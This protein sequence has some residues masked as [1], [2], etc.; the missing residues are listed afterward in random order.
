MK[1]AERFRLEADAAL[2]KFRIGRE[3]LAEISL[4]FPIYTFIN[5]FYSLTHLQFC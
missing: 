3:E 4:T 1:I 5:K 2:D